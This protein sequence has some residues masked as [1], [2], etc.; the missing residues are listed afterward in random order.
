MTLK[1]YMNKKGYTNFDIYDI[2][3]ERGYISRKK[4][5]EMP[6]EDHQI[7]IASGRRKGDIFI[8]LPCYYS[9]QYCHRAYIKFR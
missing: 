5:I 7:H 2:K 4:D 6:Y 3:L 1:E 8:Y 9:S